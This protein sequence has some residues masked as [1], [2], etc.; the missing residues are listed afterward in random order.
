[1]TN[2]P[3]NEMKE[4][5]GVNLFE[6]SPPGAR[7]WFVAL[8]GNYFVLAPEKTM[9]AAGMKRVTEDGSSILDTDHYTELRGKLGPFQTGNSGYVFVR[10]D[11][12]WNHLRNTF[13][14]ADPLTRLVRKGAPDLF[15][16]QNLLGELSLRD[17]SIEVSG[18]GQLKQNNL[19]EKE[20]RNMEEGFRRRGFFLPEKTMFHRRVAVPPT[21]YYR[22][23]KSGGSPEEKEQIRQE[24]E[25][26]NELLGDMD[27]EEEFIPSLG[28]GLVYGLTVPG[29]ASGNERI[30]EKVPPNFFAMLEIRKSRVRKKLN[31]LIQEWFR[32]VRE[33][34][35]EMQSRRE[36]ISTMH[37]EERRVE[38]KTIYAIVE[39]S[40]E[41]PDGVSGYRPGYTFVGSYFV[42]AMNRDVLYDLVR[43]G[44]E[45]MEAIGEVPDVYHTGLVL[46]V[47]RLFEMLSIYEDSI[48][49]TIVRQRQRRMVADR[50]EE[51]KRKRITT[52]WK[53][54]KKRQIRK[55]LLREGL[56]PET[57]AFE[58]QMTSMMESEIY[59]VE[60]KLYDEEIQRFRRNH[61][62]DHEQM[63]DDVRTT[64]RRF[65]GS[66]RLFGSIQF[67]RRAMNDGDR[68]QF[69]IGLQ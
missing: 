2:S 48:A 6:F 67:F 13:D 55:T 37:V 35:R 23:L 65:R 11:G 61:S 31:H 69:T 15:R 21:A 50:V 1:M 49:S 25:T 38:N 64:L 20:R 36:G 63:L 30:S 7:S 43:N 4:V 66:H 53:R 59:R 18:V 46:R 54:R 17:R 3:W 26:M 22:L 32:R 45:Q 40:Q 44:G 10:P 8:E 51:R 41:K 19:V 14:A 34:A 28:P 47:N 29:S 56:E 39:E 16:T 9:A 42:V 60:S 12:L 27:F 58:R 5:R 57:E 62:R 52:K 24:V 33:R 68:W